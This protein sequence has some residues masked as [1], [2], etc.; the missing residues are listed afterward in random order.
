MFCAR[1]QRYADRGHRFGLLVPSDPTPNKAGRD[2]TLD[3]QI[4]TV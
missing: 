3:I 4:P 2:K 1:R